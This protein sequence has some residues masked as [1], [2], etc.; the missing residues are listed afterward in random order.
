MRQILQWYNITA[1]HVPPHPLQAYID[2]TWG[3]LF[4]YYKLYCTVNNMS[5]FTP[6]VSAVFTEVWTSETDHM[7]NML[8]A[9]SGT[10]NLKCS[11]CVVVTF[12]YR[13]VQVPHRVGSQTKGTIKLF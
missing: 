11:E 2:A 6:A 10:N 7:E 5:S 8:T 13:V 3:Y 1:H 12:F 4:N 9:A